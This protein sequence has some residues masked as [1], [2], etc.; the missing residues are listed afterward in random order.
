MVKRI[1][2]ILMVLVLTMLTFAGCRNN[3]N[4]TEENNSQNANEQITLDNSATIDPLNPGNYSTS[5]NAVTKNDEVITCENGEFSWKAALT[6]SGDKADY[7]LVLFVDG[8]LT[9]FT[10]DFDEEEKTMHILS[11][12]ANKVGEFTVKVK[13]EYIPSGHTVYADVATI[14][15]PK[16]I[17]Q[18]L[19]Y[20]SYLPH[21][22]L[23]AFTFYKLENLEANEVGNINVSQIDYQMELPDEINKSY[24]SEGLDENYETVITNSLDNVNF[25]YLYS[26]EE[27]NEII[28]IYTSVPGKDL[29]LKVACLGK[30]EKFR[31]SLYINHTPVPAFDGNMYCDVEVQRDKIMF[32][33]V[34]ISADYLAGLGEFNHIYLMAVPIEPSLSDEDYDRPIK[35]TTKMLYISSE[36]NVAEIES[37]IAADLAE[38]IYD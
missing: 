11:L 20:R 28:S 4:T 7:G 31:L 10:T 14:L 30:S 8:V 18:S 26:G 15:N 19:D 1:F 29:N 32:K 37:Q 17:L 3:K 23:A 13:A 12:G 2:C 5:L 34:S 6:N 27:F 22:F 36:E 16:Y 24:E 25:F 21:H 9:P 38:V 35:T 33:N